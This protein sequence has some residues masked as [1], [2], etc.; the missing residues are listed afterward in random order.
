MRTVRLSG[1]VLFR[2]KTALVPM[3]RIQRRYMLQA[4]FIVSSPKRHA[5]TSGCA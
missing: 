2:A 5:A 1:K 4:R 3:R